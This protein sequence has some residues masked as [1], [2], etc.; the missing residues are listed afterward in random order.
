M[1]PEPLHMISG[2]MLFSSSAMLWSFTM[3]GFSGEL[4]L[5][6]SWCNLGFFN[7]ETNVLP[8]SLSSIFETHIIF[9]CWTSFLF[10]ISVSF[11]S[12]FWWCS[13]TLFSYL[14]ISKHK[15]VS[16][17][18]H[19]HICMLHSNKERRTPLSKTCRPSIKGKWGQL[20]QRAVVHVRPGEVILSAV[21]AMGYC[22]SLRQLNSQVYSIIFC[23][24]D[25][26][27]NFLP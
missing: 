5:P 14:S 21:R 10:S 9:G 2:S 6:I 18:S 23:W 16:W 7:M 8:S 22:I 12:A 15:H 24:Q 25:S 20:L 13:T 3:I 26:L 11:C 27:K 19:H 17:K 4:F 1:I